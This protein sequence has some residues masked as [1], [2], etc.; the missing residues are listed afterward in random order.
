[1]RV[2]EIRAYKEKIRFT[3]ENAAEGSSVTI[4]ARVPLV[5]GPQDDSFVEGRV[6]GTHTA[7]IENG[8]ADMPRYLDGYD[9][10]VCRFSCGCEGICYV[11]EIEEEVS[12][13]TEEYPVL[14]I[15]AIGYATEEDFEYMG[16]KQACLGPNQAL[17]MVS[18]GHPDAMEY[19]HNGK[20]YY[21][22]RKVIESYDA[23]MAPLAQK[24][25]ACVLRYINSS[26]SIG[27][28]ADQDIV[29]IIQHPGYD[30]DYPSAYMG[31]FNL[32][33]E[34]GFNHFCACTEFLVERYCRA[35]RKYGWAISFEVGNEV[36][37]QYIWGNAGDMTCA[38]YMYEYTEVMPS[39]MGRPPMART[40]SMP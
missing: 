8:M 39:I 26:F 29:D 18:K 6:V 3:F 32:R 11:T 28:Q 40:S 13:H 2:T 38:E 1:M 20:T 36:T 31:A 5:C 35:D 30:Y 7:V 33:T 9:V 22:N 17:M 25:V 37:S 10:L 24:G 15:K 4:A 14:P 19:V 23:H 34:E 16:F 12:E 27:E 21:F